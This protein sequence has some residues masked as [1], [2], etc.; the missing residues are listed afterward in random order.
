MKFI[1]YQTKETNMKQFLFLCAFVIFMTMTTQVN[2]QKIFEVGSKYDAD[3]KVFVVDSKYDADLIVYKVDS[4]Y[5]VDK[6]GRWFFVDS[7]YDADKKV[8]FV[9]SKYDADLKIY[10]AS[11]KYDAKWRESGKKHTMH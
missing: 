3:V 8:Y 6:N 5:D 4:K 2:A 7:K 11:S 9:D 1:L 10:Y